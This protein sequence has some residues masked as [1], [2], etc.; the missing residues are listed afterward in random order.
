MAKKTI[1]LRILKFIL[2]LAIVPAI[3]AEIMF[4]AGA[5]G[6]GLLWMIAG[7]GFV[8]A[9]I[10][11]KLLMGKFLPNA[12]PAVRVLAFSS[13]YVLVLAVIFAVI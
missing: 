2:L 13:V 3:V 4:Q 7:A 9:W 8:A 5:G 11:E 10:L 6:Y 1:L 12:N